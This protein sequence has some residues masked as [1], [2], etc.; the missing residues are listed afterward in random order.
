MYINT[1]M[2]CTPYDI[3]KLEQSMAPEEQSFD[4]INKEIA[5]ITDSNNLSYSSGQVIFDA[6][7]LATA[8]AF[9]DWSAA[10]AQIPISLVLSTTGGTLS[11]AT[12]NYMA[13]CLKGSNFSITTCCQ[14]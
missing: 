14:A 13:M 4:F 8:T 12:E 6:T 10:T 11:G 1:T 5:L 3:W 7:A 9:S 2:S